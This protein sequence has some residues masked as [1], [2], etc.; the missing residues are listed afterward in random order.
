M[1]EEMAPLP[2]VPRGEQPVP[3]P[4]E[5]GSWPWLTSAGTPGR[6]P[7]WGSPGDR[8]GYPREPHC[9]AADPALDGDPVCQPREENTHV[10]SCF[11][12]WELME[13]GQVVVP[14]R[15]NRAKFPGFDS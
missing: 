9:S 8:S 4:G 3:V 15:L 12:A 6:P 1:N 14:S 7:G 5:A 13:K 10:W 2:K 11:P